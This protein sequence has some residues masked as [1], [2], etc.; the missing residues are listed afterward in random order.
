MAGVRRIVHTFRF[1]VS[2]VVFETSSSRG[3]SNPED[4]QQ[5]LALLLS[6]LL[7]N[8]RTRTSPPG[9]GVQGGLITAPTDPTQRSQNF[10]HLETVPFR[11]YIFSN[12]ARTSLSSRVASRSLPPG[13]PS[14]P[15]TL[16]SS[17]LPS[18]PPPWR[19]A[20]RQKTPRDRIII[21]IIIIT[22]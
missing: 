5:Q 21:I 3:S 7:K 18:Q 19:L 1:D 13:S 20:K 12:E 2:K 6:T 22:C 16:A 4:L 8:K 11:R 9:R 17:L 14:P 15:P 10:K